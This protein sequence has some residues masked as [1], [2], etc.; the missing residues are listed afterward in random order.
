MNDFA[1][2]R[3][4][5]LQAADIV[6]YIFKARSPSCGIGDVLLMESL[7]KSVV[8][9]TNGRFC[10]VLMERWPELPMANEVMMSD[11]KQRVK[12]LQR[13]QQNTVT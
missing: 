1:R 11:A 6:G 12:F 4:L 10:D 8:G 2:Q 13:V 9:K 7:G 3:V 5:Q